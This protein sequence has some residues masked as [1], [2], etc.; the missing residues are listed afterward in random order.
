MT[1][2]AEVENDPNTKKILDHGF[3]RLVDHMGSD[4]AVCEAAR[5][6]Y[7]E[8]TKSV[9]KN[10]ALVRY[11]M[12]HKHTSP[13]EMCQVKLH[14]KIPIFV[15]RQLVR[16]R[17]ASLNEYSGR[18]SVMTDEFYLPDMSDILPQSNSNNQ[19]RDGVIS[20]KNAKGAQWLINAANENSYQIYQTLLNTL[21]KGEE[22][23]DALGGDDP[24]FDDEYEGIARELAR[25]VLP[26]SNYTELYWSQNLHNLLHLIR[27]R[28][29]SHAQKEIRVLA[30]AIYQLVEPL[31][32]ESIRAFDDY[33]RLA[34]T[35][36]RMETELFKRLIASEKSAK[37]TYIDWLKEAGSDK[38][39]AKQNG[40]SNREFVEFAKKWE[41]PLTADI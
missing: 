39:F 20:E 2:V 21:E 29:D 32:P 18:Y 19:G 3:V 14:I 34:H 8:G 27:L 40:L 12:K 15:M 5:T 11:L 24:L 7:G 36:S 22:A 33:V 30:E 25:T 23:Y 28:W 10:T 9:S 38:E 26:V 13:F 6:S 16:H 31:F 1:R 41:F 17:T 4:N 37:A 35:L